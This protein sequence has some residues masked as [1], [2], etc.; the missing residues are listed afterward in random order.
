MRPRDANHLLFLSDVDIAGEQEI[1][2]TDE[3]IREQKKMEEK[4]L[5]SEDQKDAA[6]A[7][8]TEQ[9]HKIYKQILHHRFLRFRS[10]REQ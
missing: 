5:R 9:R 8:I 1:K 4:V 10:L 3:L 6:Q 7:R 2:L